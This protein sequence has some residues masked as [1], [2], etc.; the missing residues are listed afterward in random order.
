MLISLEIFSQHFP[1]QV[2][3]LTEAS[4]ILEDANEV[5]DKLGKEAIEAG[6]RVATANNLDRIN[7]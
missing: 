4:F 3:K 6:T 7:M 1:C 2:K 5:W